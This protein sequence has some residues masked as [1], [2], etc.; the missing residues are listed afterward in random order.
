MPVALHWFTDREP[1]PR[2]CIP[3][4]RLEMTLAGSAL[5]S[6]LLAAT[7]RALVLSAIAAFF[8]PYDTTFVRGFHFT[9]A[10]AQFGFSF[11]FAS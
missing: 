3:D 4:T 2:P 10:S 7:G 8:R 9:T 11:G 6:S 1:H 5:S